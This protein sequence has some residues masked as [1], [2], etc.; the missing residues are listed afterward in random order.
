MDAMP[1]LRMEDSQGNSSLNMLILVYK[2]S[3]ESGTSVSTWSYLAAWKY[4]LYRE[5]ARPA[6]DTLVSELYKQHI[7]SSTCC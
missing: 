4:Q 7:G 6:F 1:H 2:N 5:I 3:G